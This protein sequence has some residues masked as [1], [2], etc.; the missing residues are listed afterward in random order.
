MTRELSGRDLAQAAFAALELDQLDRVVE[1]AGRI[2]GPMKANGIRDYLLGS[3]QARRGQHE[4]ALQIARQ[5][6]A[7][8]PFGD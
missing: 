1:L 6:G 3:V 8:D 4:Q 5:T 7:L 2:E